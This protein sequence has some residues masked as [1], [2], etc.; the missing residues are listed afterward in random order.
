MTST[1]FHIFEEQTAWIAAIISEIQKDLPQFESFSFAFSGGTTPAPIYQEL[2]QQKF[3]WENAT[4]FQTDERFINPENP[5][6]NQRL[7]QENF[8]QNFPFFPGKIHHFETPVSNTWEE[9]A[10]KYDRLLHELEPIIDICL[11]GAGEDG[12]IASLF[13]NGP[14]LLETDKYATTAETNIFPVWKRLTMTFPII[15]NSKKIILLLRGPA[16]KAVI[17]ELQNGKKSWQN[18]PVKKLLEHNN[19]HI[20]FLDEEAP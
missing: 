16:K 14:E 13:P 20:F 15:M 7:I 18:F 10:A 8:V 5:E 2:S 3:S 12:H 19:S 17:S 6:S 1:N 4:I 11:L 9:A